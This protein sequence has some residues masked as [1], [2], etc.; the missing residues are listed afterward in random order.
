[1]S[2]IKSGEGYYEYELVN[3]GLGPAIIENFIVKVD[4]DVIPG[5]GV[6]KI[7][8]ALK[9]IFSEFNYI[10]HSAYIAAEY[11]MAAKEKVAIVSVQFTDK[12]FPSKDTVVNLFNRVDFYI[13]Y[14]S[15]YEEHFIWSSKK[16]KIM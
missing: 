12:P 16:T 5:K 14:K 3:N 13:D 1:M 9:V 7:E 8:K 11:S 6:D 4:D 15:F 10:S 2:H